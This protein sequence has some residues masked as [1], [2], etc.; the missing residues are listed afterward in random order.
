MANNVDLV[1]R[2]LAEDKASAAFKKAGEQVDKTGSSYEKF[3]KKARNALIGIGVTAFAIDSVKSF[4]E[5]QDASSAL[6]ATYGETGQAFIDWA[7]KSGDA[8]NLSKREALAAAQSFAIF[9]HAAGLSGKE[10]ES[11]VTPLVQRAADTASYFGGTTADAVEAFTAA[12]RGEMEPA[13]KYGVLL[14]DMTLRT[15]ALEMGLIA[16]TKNALTPQQKALVAQQLILA[17]T[18]QAQGDVARTSDSM[19]NRIKDAQ[20]QFDD[21]KVSVGETLSTAVGPMLGGLNSMLGAFNAL[22]QPVKTVTVGAL[23]AGAAF[24]YLGPKI[25]AAKVAAVGAAPALR[26]VGGILAGPWGLA[27]TAGV[28][29]L[30]AFASG[31]DDATSST[32]DFTD[33]LKASNGVIDE[34]VRRLAAKKAQDMGLL[35]AAEK[36][37]ISTETVIDA[38][39]GNADAMLKLQAATTPTTN[40]V[41]QFSN[42]VSGSQ[43]WGGQFNQTTGDMALNVSTLKSGVNQLSG[44]M[45]DAAASADQVNRAVDPMNTG[46]KDTAS[47]AGEATKK[48]KSLKEAVDDLRGTQMSAEQATANLNEAIDKATA[49]VKENGKSLSLNTEKGRANRAALQDIATAALDGVDAWSKNGASAATVAA[50][51]QQA[52]DEFIKTAIKMGATKTEA[53][54]LATAYGLIPKKVATTVTAN[55]QPATTKLDA[56]TVYLQKLSRR[57]YTVTVNGDVNAHGGTHSAA[58]QY[59][60]A[61]QASVV[62]E[63]GPEMFVPRSGGRVVP[64]SST[65]AGMGGD[66]VAA[67]VYVQIDGKNVAESQVVL[68]RRNGGNLPYL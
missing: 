61:G 6:S 46:I 3:S 35:D 12:L 31:S 8:L 65:R 2:L 63:Y 28:G 41:D 56:L 27:L 51:T 30:A 67:P 68:K 24:L 32:N 16:N 14:D 20:Q 36:L 1:M 4:A 37:G 25:Q 38:I 9:G 29:I 15:K 49:S 64:A 57:A 19:A 43:M 62:G 5:V 48:V 26:A 34:N 22:P 59:L 53:E 7:N 54:K 47:A 42:V 21:L 58:G 60:R 45:K 10:L 11:Y 55:T 44:Q 52:R 39:L 18:S 13:R 50:K 33:A 66:W 23:A 40:A 17:Q